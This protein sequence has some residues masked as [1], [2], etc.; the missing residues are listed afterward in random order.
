MRVPLPACVAAA[1]FCLALPAY[2][3]G[4]HW[5]TSFQQ[6]VAQAKVQD[7]G[8]L[9]DFTGSDWCPWCQK[10]DRDVLERQAFADF[11]GTRLVLEVVDFPNSKYQSPQLKA[12]N[13]RLAKRFN[14]AGYPTIIVL[15]KN[16]KVLGRI[17]GYVVGGEP[18]FMNALRGIYRAGPGNNNPVPS[19][20]PGSTPDDFD[21]FFKQAAS[22]TPAGPP[23][24]EVF[25]AGTQNTTPPQTAATPAATP[26][27]A[28]AAPAQPAKHSV[29]SK[30]DQEAIAM[31]EDGKWEFHGVKRKFNPDGTITSDNPTKGTWKVAD[32]VL[33]VTFAKVVV[34]YLLPIDPKGTDGETT[35]GKKMPLHKVP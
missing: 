3:E 7:K 31:L 13:Q 17:G 5:V 35:A 8:I 29:P 24:E 28:P 16:E 23:V 2:S 32:G 33:T 14:V 22:P 19:A 9:L 15:D 6:A 30:G 12:Q 27:A 11:A 34:H 10:L 26:A 21:S 25:V 20:E 18:A 1:I 4:V